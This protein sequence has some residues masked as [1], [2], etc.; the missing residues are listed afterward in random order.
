[1]DVFAPSASV[2]DAVAAGVQFASAE[3]VRRWSSGAL[4]AAGPDAT[5][6]ELFGPDDGLSIRHVELAAPVRHP[7]RT[8]IGRAAEPPPIA[9]LPV[10]PRSLREGPS[11]DPAYLAVCA[12]NE[13]V[14]TAGA[15]PEAVAQLQAA[16]DRLIG[17]PDS[18][19]GLTRL[20][21]GKRGWVTAAISGKRTDYCARSVVSPGPELD[22]DE[23][24]LPR[25][26]AKRLFEPLVLGELTRAGRAGSLDEARRML[27]EDDPAAHAALERVASGRF[28]LLHRAP[29][30]HRSSIQAFRPRI[31]DEDVIRVHPLTLQAFNA[32]FDGDELDVYLPLSEHAQAE[33][34]GAVRSSACQLSP[35]NGSHIAFP[36]Q[37]MVFGCYYATVR[38]HDAASAVRRFAT[39]DAVSDAFERGEVAVHD[40]VVLG[41][42]DSTWPTT[43]GRA[44]FNRLLP[45]ALD[46]VEE[47][48]T[49]PLLR[50]LML[51]C[52]RRLGPE[53]AAR[54][55]DEIMRFGFHHATRSG[56][57]LGKDV[58]KQHSRFE[59]RLA[60]AWKQADELEARRPRGKTADEPP[61]EAVLDH[62]W[63]VAEQ[64]ADASIAELAADRDGLTALHMMLASGARGSRHQA[65]QLLAMRG[66][67]AT[68]SGRLLGTPFTTTFVR[69][70]SPLEYLASTFGARKGLADTAL[71]TARAGGL[72]KRI[73]S[74]VQDVVVCQADCGAT[75][76]VTKQTIRD[77]RQETV[78]LADRIFGRTALEDVALPG[79]AAPIVRA[80]ELIGREAAEQID[81]GGLGSVAVRSPLTCRADSGVCARCYGT[82]LSTWQPAAPGLAVG[83]IAA[84]AIGEP[85]TQLTMRTFVFAVPVTHGA[86]EGRKAG[87]SIV[88]GMPRLEQ[89][90]EAGGVP[91]QGEPEQR[92]AL[93]QMLRTD[94]AAATAE[95]LAAE[96]HRVY[97][98]QGVRIDDRHLEIV[99]REMLSRLRVT[100]AGDTALEPGDLVSAA[101]LAAANSATA[102]R[103]ATAEPTVVGV[104]EAAVSTADFI[105]AA[106]AHG[107]ASAL[108][109]AAAGKQQVPL[110]HIRNCTA[111]GR[112]V[113]PQ[114]G[115]PGD[116]AC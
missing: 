1:M 62:W 104:T 45:D 42:G 28:V 60:E 64:M 69:G 38:E 18:G 58:L 20:L 2:G 17:D 19:A 81:A 85:M 11:L 109:R 40:S 39:A 52:W 65:R 106:A 15:T 26:M 8:A 108:A 30:L 111:F 21:R 12:A 32:D 73:M 114:G 9:A 16:V 55:G 83:V 48:A 113:P 46:R 88:G 72:Y 102:A 36:T 99:L 84:Q 10:L 34:S 70:H 74:A 56:L 31:T 115:G 96:V 59:Q 50:G 92:E 51:A 103:A 49:K 7:W 53:A 22:H 68:P 77:G 95:H 79:A 66:L 44:L 25:R 41:T 43:V 90:F 33:A 57:S 100:D 86:A 6:D 47:P 105:A 101:Q 14:R 78:P 82:D 87:E 110:R 63:R 98:R 13:T 112:L 54:L 93:L 61:S 76:G 37:D 35:T 27:R 91:D 5:F 97:R 71:K 23:C 3:A 4:G 24:G 89:L 75:D 94:G 67:F 116:P 29:A 80:G 107:G